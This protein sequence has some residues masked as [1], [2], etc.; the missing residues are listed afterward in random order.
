MLFSVPIHWHL[1]VQV[2]TLNM[3]FSVWYTEYERIIHPVKGS[4]IKWKLKH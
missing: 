2:T 1:L 3:V 4:N